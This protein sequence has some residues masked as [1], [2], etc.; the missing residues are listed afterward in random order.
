MK[1]TTLNPHQIIRLLNFMKLHCQKDASPAKRTKKRRMITEVVPSRLHFT[2]YKCAKEIKFF[3][4]WHA[5]DWISYRN[6]CEEMI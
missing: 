6:I 4:Y 1:N 5:M 3:L 2:E